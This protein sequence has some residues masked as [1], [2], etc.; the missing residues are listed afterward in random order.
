MLNTADR[1]GGA[2]RLAMSVLEG[3]E[4]LGTETWL[5]VGAKRTDHPRVVR[6]DA[7]PYVD[8]SRDQSPRRLAALRVRRRLTRSLGLEDF[9]HPWSRRVLEMAG[10]PPDL[11]V[12]DNLHGGWFD[13]R[14][15]PALSRSRPL[16]L[17]LADSWPFT[18]HCACPLGCGRWETGCG[19]CP[20][21]DI[22]PAIEHDLTRLN[23]QRKRRVFSSSRL[24]IVAP[25]RWLLERAKRSLLAPAIAEARVI[26]GA[27]DLGVFEPGDRNGGGDGRRLL[28]VSHGGADNPYKD[29]ATI[30]EAFSRLQGPAELVV[31]GG[32]KEASERVGENRLIRHLP[33]VDSPAELASLYR[34]ADIYVHAAPEE[35]FCLTAAE[36][37]ACGTPV[38]A[39]AG[40]GVREVVE[41]GR[42]GFVTDPGDSRALA[43]ALGRLMDRPELRAQMAAAGV[44]AAR[45]RFDARGVVAD[46]HAWCARIAERE[47]AR[48]PVAAGS[49]P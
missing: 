21:L 45:E 12:C 10:S 14:A 34:D 44:A 2:E 29:F 38:V 24:F 4:A 28:Y 23:W 17:R 42:T 22:P 1:G 20:D 7:S 30:R 25:S 31:V 8:Y 46:L 43:D 40:G 49:K 3:F 6:L 11:V 37:L 15:L 32:A 35:S 16:V 27:V 47:A 9:E 26:P 33:Y 39:A 5:A 36:A 19:S 48:Q 13:V 18:G 41:H